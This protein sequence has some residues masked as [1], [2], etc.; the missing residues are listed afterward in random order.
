MDKRIYFL[1]IIAFVIGSVEL[2]ISGILDL[3]AE[4]LN[5]SIGQAGLLITVFALIFAVASP[6]LLVLT[7]KIERKVLTLGCLY[8][9]FIGCIVT[10]FSPTFSVLFIG[11]IILALSGALL[12][13]LCLVMAPSLAGNQYKGRAIGI[14]SMGVS[15]SLVLGVPLGLIIGNSFGW[16]AP[17]VLITVM[18]ALSIIGVHA[19]MGRIEPKSQV[20]LRQQLAAFKNPKITLGLTT[21]FLYM[22]GHSIMYSYF[23]PYLEATTVFNGNWVSIIYLIFGVAAVFGGGIGGVMADLLGTRKTMVI[24]LAIFS[25]LFFILPFTTGL[26]PIFFIIIIAWGILSWAISPAM[27][28][29]LIESAPESSEI[30]QSLNNSALHLGVAGG[31]VIG[32]GIVDTLSVE[33]NPFAGGI[34]IIMSLIT[35]VI[36]VNSKKKT[37]YAAK[38]A[39]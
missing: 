19:F 23:K 5:V 12:I 35:V 31:S 30:Q 38:S 7:A 27:Q 26:F 1:M 34:L 18:T 24:S 8:V 10:V 16:R 20:P 29:Y 2:I 37:S 28:S 13:I 9:F 25:S 33:V 21:T 39:I 22:T 32:A 11:R 15:A 3:I 6:I 36:S 4:D 14:V 17:F